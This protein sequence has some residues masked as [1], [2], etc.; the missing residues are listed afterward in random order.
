M[1]RMY[2]FVCDCGQRTEALEVYETS[3]VLCRCG[4]LASRVISAP[5]FNLEGWSGSFPSEHGR[6]ERKHREKLNAE[7]KANS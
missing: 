5:S 3:N 2:E 4:G 1:K 7:R 6:F